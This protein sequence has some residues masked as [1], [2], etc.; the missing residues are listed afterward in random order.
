MLDFSH[1]EGRRVLAIGT[2]LIECERVAQ[3]WDRQGERFLR[4]IFT[5]GEQAYC[6]QMKNPVPHLAARFAAK[7]AVSKCFTTG[8]GGSLNWTSVEVVKGDRG[9]PYVR[10][11]GK[12]AELLQ[13]LGGKEVLLSLSHTKIYGLAFAAL[14]A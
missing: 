7:E 9:E 4:R 10:L 6:L 12:G 14:L 1:P 11:R 5:E 3:V 8:I 2:D 13:Q